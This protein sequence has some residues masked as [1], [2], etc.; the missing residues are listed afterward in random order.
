VSGKFAVR[1]ATEHDIDAV[2]TILEGRREW[3]RTTKLSDQ[4]ASVREWRHLL[5][6]LVRRGHVRVLV[7]ED[8][9]RVAGT[10][11]VGTDPDRD[12][13]S[14]G[15]RRR[16]ALYLSKLATDVDLKGQELG[17][18]LLE[19]AWRYA[20]S[21][22]IPV[23]RLD[24][25]K[26]SPGL[27]HYYTTRGWTHVRIVDLGHRQSGSLFQREVDIPADEAE[28]VDEPTGQFAISTLWAA[29][30]S[31]HPHPSPSRT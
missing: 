29:A 24:T 1:R 8:T 27:R 11:T 31:V 20:A 18:V 25:W 23:L 28:L 7:D 3:L 4:W 30:A 16:P 14:D 21:Q 5:A 15:E 22:G 13:W 9:G 26:T 6:Y 17:N 2:M 19:W 12:F 10:I